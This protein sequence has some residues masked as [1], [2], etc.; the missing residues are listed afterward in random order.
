MCP[1]AAGDSQHSRIVSLPAELKEALE[2]QFELNIQAQFPVSG[3]CIHRACAL[4]SSEGKLFVK[5]NRASEALQFEAEVQ[6]LM[7]LRSVAALPVPQIWG[8][9]SSP[10]YAGL[11]LAY[12][13]PTRRC[14]DFWAQLGTGLAA[15][16]RHH[17]AYFGLEESN[18]IGRLPQRNQPHSSWAEFFAEERLWPLALQAFDAQLLPL[19]QL[20]QMESLLVRLPQL[21]PESIPSLLHGDLWTGNLLAGPQGM[22]YLIDPA[23]Y[24]GEREAEL[25]FT[26]LFGG[27]DPCFYQAYEAVWPLPSGWQ[28]RVDLF[29]LYPLLVHLNLFGS[30]YLGQI[31]RILRVLS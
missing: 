9:V 13:E 25:A 11:V 28:A 8:P 10:N 5:W 4:D 19:T 21:M 22:P 23:V 27:F 30:A 17:Q 7:R 31:Q 1:S 16:H 3:G 18:Y 2:R 20:R 29:N 24:Y 12:L 6:G 15:L 26:R 14:A